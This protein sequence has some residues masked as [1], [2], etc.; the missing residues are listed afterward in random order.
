M[1][2]GA[3]HTTDEEL[4]DEV[5]CVDEERMRANVVAF[6]ARRTRTLR[7][8]S[9]DARSRRQTTSALKGVGKRR[10]NS[11]VLAQRAAWEGPRWT[12]ARTDNRPSLTAE[13]DWKE[14]MEILA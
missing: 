3:F 8:C 1:A 11:P 13:V 10:L 5:V 4:V 9:F 7:R 12:R 2:Q 6:R 14:D